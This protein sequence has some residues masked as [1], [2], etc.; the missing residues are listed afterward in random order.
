M[1]GSGNK[2]GTVAELATKI[3]ATAASATAATAIVAGIAPGS[4]ETSA[5]AGTTSAAAARS[6]VFTGTSLVDCQCPTV[7]F[8]SVERR[9]GS[10][11]V[12]I[13]THRDEGKPARTPGEFIL[14]QHDFRNGAVLREH[15]LNGDLRRVERQIANI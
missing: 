4:V 13:G 5:T 7:E 3:A 8:F 1:T 15:V 2:N 14:H 9:N 12:R 10:L 6:A 11:G